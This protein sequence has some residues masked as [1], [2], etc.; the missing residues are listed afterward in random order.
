MLILGDTCLP[1]KKV[2][3]RN[4]MMKKILSECKKL[5]SLI[6]SLVGI[7]FN[8]LSRQEYDNVR[9]EYEKNIN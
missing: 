9:I 2:A 1:P 5:R 7:H 8:M 4:V 3:F 6:E